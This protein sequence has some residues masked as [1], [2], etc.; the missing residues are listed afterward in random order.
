MKM[1][2]IISVLVIFTFIS[3]RFGYLEK[4]FDKKAMV[5]FKIN[6]VTGWITNT[7][8][9][10]PNNSRSNQTMKFGHLIEHE[11]TNIFFL[12]NQTQNVVANP[13][14]FYKKSKLIISLDKQ[15]AMLKGLLLLYVHVEVY[16]NILKLRCWPL[17][18]TLYK[19]FLKAKRGLER[20]S[21][22][23]FLHNF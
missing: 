2:F 9:I 7:R 4:W 1:L 8:Y 3:W 10:L 18:F 15:F 16:Q 12:L 22:H 21:L 14:H 11:T 13:W 20:F 17:A 6:D 23:P 5:N 19:T